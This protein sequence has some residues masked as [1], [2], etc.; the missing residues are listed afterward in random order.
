MIPALGRANPRRYGAGGAYLSA[1]DSG[2][3]PGQFTKEGGAGATLARADEFADK[4][5]QFEPT[6]AKH[7]TP[8][9]P[10]MALRLAAWRRDCA[11]RDLAQAVAEAR[12]AD[13]PWRDV[14]ESLGTSGEAARK[15]YATA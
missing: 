12:A 5:E 15:R 11:E 2:H 9:P 8:L 14:G 13:T 7:E 10:I 6:D 1:A 4:F 3:N